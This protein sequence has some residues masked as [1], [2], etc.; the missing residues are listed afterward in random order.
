MA[1]D[2]ADVNATGV[3]DSVW[4]SRPRLTDSAESCNFG[5]RPESR[6]L[7]AVSRRKCVRLVALGVAPRVPTALESAPS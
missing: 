7:A 3:A 5:L 4:G 1:T 2:C 6:A